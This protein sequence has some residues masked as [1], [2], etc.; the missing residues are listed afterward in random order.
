MMCK[1]VNKKLP[2]KL[3][4]CIYKYIYN[5]RAPLSPAV[6][7]TNPVLLERNVSFTGIT[8][9]GGVMLL[10]ILNTEVNQL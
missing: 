10:I 6:T 2:C 5:E 1:E 8:V 4:C 7:L 3:I 9:R